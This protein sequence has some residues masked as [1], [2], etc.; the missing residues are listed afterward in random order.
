MATTTQS[1]ECRDRERAFREYLEDKARAQR[2]SSHESV[3]LV[4]LSTVRSECAHH[5]KPR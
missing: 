5:A 3:W 4:R 1:T 2:L